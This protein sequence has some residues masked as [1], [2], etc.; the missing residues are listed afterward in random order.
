MLSELLNQMDTYLSN[1]P[2]KRRW[3]SRPWIV[4]MSIQP[5][6][7][8]ECPLWKRSPDE[9]RLLRLFNLSPEALRLK[10]E[11]YWKQPRWRRWLASFGMNKKID[12]WNYYQRCLAYQAVRPDKLAPESF[13][14][15]SESRPLLH[16]LGLVLHQ[17]HIQFEAY[18]E[19][20]CRN[21][22]W[23][24]KYFLQEIKRYQQQ[25]QKIFLTKLNNSLKQIKREED[26]FAL[27]QQA[28]QEY[29]QV[30]ALMWRYFEPQ[31]HNFISRLSQP[32]LVA[33]I[34]REVAQVWHR[35]N[36]KR[37]LAVYQDTQSVSFVSPSAL[38]IEVNH[39]TGISSLDGAKEWIQS[40]REDLKLLLKEGS[41]QKVE[42]LLQAS[43][44]EI[45]AN[46][47]LYLAGCET[48]MRHIQGEHEAY[49]GF[50][51]YLN[52]LQR[53]LKPVL[54]GGMLLFHPDHAMS[55]T[56]SQAMWELLSRY[57]QVYLQQ[58]RCYL[59]RFKNYHLRL[60]VLYQQSLGDWSD[61]ARCIRELGESVKD[62]EQSFK[63]FDKKLKETEEQRVKDKKAMELKLKESEEQRLKDKKA[64]EEQRLKDKEAMEEQRLK[65][66]EAMEKQLKESEEQRLKDKEAMDTQMKELRNLINLRKPQQAASST[67]ESNTDMP[68]SSHVGFFK[69]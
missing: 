61:L 47:E 26:R 2:F 35:A 51:K 54:Q 69:P 46:I 5:P 36:L 28:E 48:T 41:L 10:I 9:L 1:K 40:Q 21:P 58:S 68:E 42:A 32:N 34:R 50:S 56:H 44:D 25:S 53:R 16:E 4:H 20:R 49:D 22:R 17:S 23:I 63:E 38:P 27:K 3:W 57:S 33:E 19:K 65:D 7:S 66:K 8:K 24:E 30:E 59:G 55:L 64:M 39:Q 11:R 15:A 52:N 13:F 12:V 60:E 37:D 31:W 18:L 6:L 62:L 29:Q 43:L 67:S 14:L 45:K